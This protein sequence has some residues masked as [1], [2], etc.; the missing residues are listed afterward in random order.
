MKPLAAAT[1]L[2][3]FMAVSFAQ[4]NPKDEPDKVEKYQQDLKD[5]PADSLTHSLTKDLTER[6]SPKRVLAQSPPISPKYL[7][8]ISTTSIQI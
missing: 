1:A 6:D 8:K 5:N 7:P 4:P 3:A 2:L